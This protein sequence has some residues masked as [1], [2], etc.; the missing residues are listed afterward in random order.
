MIWVSRMSS[1][2]R[3]LRPI[4]LAVLASSTADV[5]CGLTLDIRPELR[6]PALLCLV[7]DDNEQFVSCR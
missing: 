6:V 1:G 5:V 3:G 2:T 4:V 7:A